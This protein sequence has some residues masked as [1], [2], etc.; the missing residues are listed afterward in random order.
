MTE[1]LFEETPDPRL[2][3]RPVRPGTTVKAKTTRHSSVDR[4]C[5]GRTRRRR[6]GYNPTLGEPSCIPKRGKWAAL[7]FQGF[8]AERGTTA[9][10]PAMAVPAAVTGRQARRRGRSAASTDSPRHP[11]PAHLLRP[12]TAARSAGTAS[13]AL[14]AR[15]LDTGAL[16]GVGAA[17]PIPD[18]PLAN[19][20]RG[21][22]PEGPFEWA[23]TVFHPGPFRNRSGPG[24]VG[25]AHVRTRLAAGKRYSARASGKNIR[26]TISGERPRNYS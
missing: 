11:G 1:E 8:E 17:S 3:R 22:P 10:R 20:P 5:C 21:H 13:A 16:P 12:P 18:A 24:T 4:A 23:E 7:A 14:P 15:P 6:P 25:K 26:T 9:A 19:R 2:Q